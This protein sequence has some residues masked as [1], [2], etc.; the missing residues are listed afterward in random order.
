MKKKMIF[1]I[2]ILLV[3][4]LVSPFI[5]SLFKSR[6]Y[7]EDARRRMHVTA[8]RGGASLGPE[9]TLSCIEQ[10][11]EAG[12]DA[13]EVDIHMTKDGQLI[14]CHDQTVD[15]TTNGHGS[16]CDMT[17]A[18]IQRLKVVDAN[19]DLTDEHLPT[20]AEVLELID[21][22][23]QLLLEIKRT[24]SLYQGIEQKAI[25]E[26]CR[27]DAEAW[28]V[29]QSFNDS[30][31]E[32]LHA[33]DPKLRLEKLIVVKFVGLP[34]IFDVG[35]NTFNFEK[36]SYVASFNICDKALTQSF[37]DEVHAHGKEVKVWTLEDVA[38]AISWPVD[39]VITNRPDDWKR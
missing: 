4:Y 37:I 8:H 16:I 26:I 30:V 35:L 27:H 5:P 22:R 18:E 32:N 2:I 15:R 29:W 14:V 25:D 10:G 19:G 34:V 6:G 17:L 23:C 21:G 20:L 31:L 13:I 9:N 12:A 33:I 39:G 3:F 38:S 36:Y 1:A 7:D 11:I 24:G 28:T